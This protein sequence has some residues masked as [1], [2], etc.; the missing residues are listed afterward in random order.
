V[1]ALVEKVPFDGLMMRVASELVAVTAD[2]HMVLGNI[3][4]EEY[5]SDTMDGAGKS[6]EECMRRI[7]R[8]VCADLD[9]LKP[10]EITAIAEYVYSRQVKR[11]SEALLEV[12]VRNNI[13]NVVTTG[14]GM[15]IIGAKASEAAGLKYTGMDKIL[16]KEDCVVA[17]AVG[18]ALLMEQF[19]RNNSQ[20]QISNP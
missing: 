10:D 5:T 1:A 7:S 8:V 19:L 9:T 20:S 16:N 2:I 17:P 3:T 18:T 13:S 11:I 6:V 14:L 4:E 12:S 15:D